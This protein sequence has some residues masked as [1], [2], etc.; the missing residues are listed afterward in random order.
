[1]LEA[2]GICQNVEPLKFS[3]FVPDVPCVPLSCFR[4]VTG[5]DCMRPY[6]ARLVFL[7]FNFS[8]LEDL[9]YYNFLDG[10]LKTTI[11]SHLVT[12]ICLVS[13]M[14]EIMKDYLVMEIAFFPPHGVH[15]DREIICK[16]GNILNDH[17]FNTPYGPYHF[18]P[19]APYSFPGNFLFPY[20]KECLRIYIQTSRLPNILPSLSSPCSCNGEICRA[21]P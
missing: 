20:N 21:K 17:Q 9:T 16:I 5:S 13:S 15:F 11:E 19:V 2:K 6:L 1:M 3:K 14:I 4:N 8:N 10:S 7:S 18:N 12:N